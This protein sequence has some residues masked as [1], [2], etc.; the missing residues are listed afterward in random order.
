MGEVMETVS[1]AAGG[2]DIRVPKGQPVQP[3]SSLGTTVQYRRLSAF[4][5]VP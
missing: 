1:L 4:K 2:I 5:L 3:Q